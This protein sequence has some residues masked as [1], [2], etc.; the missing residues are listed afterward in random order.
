MFKNLYK[1][2]SSTIIAAFVSAL[3]YTEMCVILILISWV[4]F[5]YFLF[6]SKTAK[7]ALKKGAVFGFIYG[8]FLFKWIFSSLKEYTSEVIIGV[9]VIVLLSIIYSLVYALLSYLFFIIKKFYS[10]KYFALSLLSIASVLTLFDELLS[11]LFIGIPFLNLRVGFT[12]SNSLYLVQFSKYGGV[13]ILTFI[14]FFINA[15]IADYFNRKS[16]LL[17]KY[18]IVFLPS[19]YLLGYV[20]YVKNDSLESKKIKVSVAT[21]NISPKISWDAKNGSQLAQEYFSLCKQASQSNP[22]FILWPESTIPWVFEENDDLVAEFLKINQSNAIHVI[23]VNKPVSSDKTL[24][25]AAFIS[26]SK[27]PQFYSKNILL[28]GFEEPLLSYFQIPFYYNLKLKYTTNNDSRP[29]KTANGKVGVLICNESIENSQVQKEINLGANYFFVLSNDGWFKDSYISLYHF[30]IARI[31]A[32]AYNRDFVI[33]SNCGY[34]GFIKNNGEIVEVNQS[35]EAYTN[36][37]L[38]KNNNEKTFYSKY[39]NIFYILLILI[40]S[41][42]TIL[43][44]K[45]LKL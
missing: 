20:L 19:L 23:G 15:C 5:F 40:L 36:T 3:A 28:K 4:P 43:S 41:I 38:T 24:N 21:A 17:L 29:I 2:Y 11:Y 37:Q 13:A 27:S 39:P 31:M 42:N 22:D 32:V 45:S 6:Q 12:L 35:N 10:I 34:S 18:L 25:S 1:E 16:K 8:L 44:I 30:Y 9:A 33:S 14:V 26:N 7:N